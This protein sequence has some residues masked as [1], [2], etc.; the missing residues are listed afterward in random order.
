MIK[1]YWRVQD[2]LAL[3]AARRAYRKAQTACLKV[4][5][6][7]D[8]PY[9]MWEALDDVRRAFGERLIDAEVQYLQGA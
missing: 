1:L 4:A 3:M 9:G 7:D 8:V 2:R 6:R 5:G